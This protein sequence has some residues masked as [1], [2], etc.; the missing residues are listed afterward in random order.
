M[1]FLYKSLIDFEN[2]MNRERIYST[3]DLVEF[4]LDPKGKLEIGIPKYNKSNIKKKKL[5]TFGTNKKY[6]Y[7]VEEILNGSKLDTDYNKHCK[8]RIYLTEKYY[9]S[10]NLFL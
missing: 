2:K 3:I 4:K 7:T 9:C 10:F 6:N 5:R 1:E 8:G